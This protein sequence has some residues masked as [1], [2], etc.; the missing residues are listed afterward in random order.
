MVVAAVVAVVVAGAAVEV[1][2]LVPWAAGVLPLLARG[3][4]EAD[5]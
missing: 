2:V 1:A 3:S 4:V 5:G